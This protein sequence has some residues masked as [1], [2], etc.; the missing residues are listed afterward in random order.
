M[1]HFLRVASEKLVW[2]FKKQRI[3]AEDKEQIIDFCP[4]CNIKLLDKKVNTLLRHERKFHPKT[5]KELVKEFYTRGMTPMF[6]MLFCVLILGS[7]VVSYGLLS[8]YFWESS[9]T[10]AEKNAHE[11]CSNLYEEYPKVGGFWESND[12]IYLEKQEFIV[13]N[14]DDLKRC[15]YSLGINSLGDK[16]ERIEHF[17]STEP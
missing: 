6:V 1:Y 5:D 2:N 3:V 15:N 4:K 8:N 14:L 12:V 13:E 17:L 9:L 16:E 10:E 7:T 11:F